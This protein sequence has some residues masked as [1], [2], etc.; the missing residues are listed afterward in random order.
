MIVVNKTPPSL[1]SEAVQTKVE[2][3]YDC[4]VATVLPMRMKWRIWQVMVFSHFII[5]ITL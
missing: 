4:E 2:E 5:L 3:A 1:P